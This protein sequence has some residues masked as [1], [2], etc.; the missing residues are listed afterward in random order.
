MTDDNSGNMKYQQLLDEEV[1]SFIHKSNS[2][3]PADAANHTIKQ[4][5]AWYTQMCLGFQPL[6][7]I[8]VTRSDYLYGHRKVPVREYLPVHCAVG[9]TTLIYFHGGGFVVGGLNS[10]DDVCADICTHTGFKVISA[11]Y[12]LS[13]EKRHPEAF[14]DAY[15]VFLSVAAQSNHKILVAGDSAGATLAACVSAKSRHDEKQP[16]AQVL[17][18]PYL[19]A[20][21]NEGSAVEHA[22]APLLTTSDMEFYENIRIDSSQ[23]RPSDET[24][25]PLRGTDF[26]NLPKTVIFSAECDPLRDDGPL[27]AEQITRAGGEANCTV[28]PGLV[29]GY[30]RARHNSDKANASFTRILD[31]ILI[32]GQ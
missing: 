9:T 15:S 10:H 4:Q 19:G 12:S 31:A 5:R 25:A 27:Y 7:K 21:N 2:Y 29:H 16:D 24:F 30:I 13:P 23:P 18:Y 1:W 3:Y 8:P 17:I 22:N 14:L 6:A 26:S 28:E 32:C 20:P 11:D